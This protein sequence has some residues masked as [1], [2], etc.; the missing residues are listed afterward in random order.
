MP[1]A[2]TANPAPLTPAQLRALGAATTRELRWGLREVADE[3]GR[4]RELAERIP[5]APTRADAMRG[6][7]RKRGHADGAALFSILPD[8]RSGA[9]LR[10]LVGYETILDFLDDVSERHATEANGR[11]LH[12]ALVDAFDLDRPLADYYRHHPWKDDG[13]YLVALVEAC[14]AACRALPSYD[15]VREHVVVEAWRA[16]VLALNHL[17][18]PG[19]RDAALSAWAA[20]EF[21]DEHGLDW[22]ELSAAASATLVILAL[23]TLA[24]R[25]EVSD[26][27]VAATRSAYWP[28]VSLTAAMLDSHVDRVEDRAA[29]D[30][31]YVAHYPDEACAARRICYCIRQAVREALRLPDGHRHAV[32]VGCMVAMYLS[33]DSARVAGM[34][35]TTRRMIRSGG[36]LCCLLQPVLR[37]WRIAYSLRSA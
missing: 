31:S 20:E 1:H 28:W 4:W 37:L 26:R 13:G 25:A 29:G 14:R 36:S 8:E 7:T 15:R 2:A 35:S 27:D 12:L 3:L 10:L 30:H 33:K 9:L 24:A 11:E 17:T 19:A 23:L 5:D 18:D 22:F 21:P 34:R 16:Q 6:L 32:I